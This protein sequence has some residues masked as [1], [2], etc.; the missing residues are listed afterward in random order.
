MKIKVIDEKSG[1]T[2]E[3]DSNSSTVKGLLQ[4]LK[5]NSETVIVARNSE[6]LLS[7]DT[8]NEGD[9]ILLLSVISGG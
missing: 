9:E 3:F 4:E 8:L 2:K 5:V 6:I 1:E 7:A